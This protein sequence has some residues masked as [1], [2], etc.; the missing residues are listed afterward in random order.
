MAAA[1]ALNHHVARV[2]FLTLLIGFGAAC[3]PSPPTIN[4]ILPSSGYPRQLLAVDGTTFLADVVWDV[5]QPTETELSNGFLGTSYF[6]IPNGASPGPHPVA[7]RNSNGTSS[8]LTVTVLAPSGN[9]PAPRIEDIGVFVH[10]NS[11]PVTLA[12][13][14]SAANL[15]V[16]AAVEVNGTPAASTVRWGAIPTDYLQSHVPA[17]YGYPIY[18]YVQLLNV[19]EDVNLGSSLS[20]SVTNSDGQSD[21][22]TYQLPVSLDQLDSDGDGLRDAWEVNSFTA[23][24]GGAVELADMGADKWRKDVPI[25][26]DW[27]AAAEPDASIWSTIEQAFADAPVLNPDG[28][29]GL[30][31]ILD[32]GQG[33]ALDQGGTVLADH[34]VMDFEATNS[35]SGYVSFYAYKNDPANFEPDR[36]TIFHYAIFG[37]ARPNGSSGRGEIWGNDF[38]VTFRNFSSWSQPIAQIGTFIHELGHNL[39]LSHGDLLTTPA[40]WSETRK[41]NFPTT[42]SYRYQFPGVSIDCDFV[43]ENIHTYSEGTFPRITESN[44]DENNG[45]CDNSALDL[46]SDG[47]LTAGA[48]DTSQDGDT[49]DVHDDFDQWG[50]LQLDFDASGSGWDSD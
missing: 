44:V 20:V 40:Q 18:H 2:L 6:Q 36:L 46:N 5:G 38:M 3:S 29:R 34:T 37:R 1:P 11:D 8:T 12:L 28:S 48:I 25:E 31:V 4:A 47:S 9:F 23:P 41:P 32:R 22:G 42:M 10:N 19:V 24:S 17:T 39:G 16:D 14:V 26:V 21:S 13:M 43:S 27:I 30:N 45:I 50:N 33:E 35:A 15:D 49:S 7:I